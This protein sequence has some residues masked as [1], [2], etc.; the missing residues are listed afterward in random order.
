[1]PR[2]MNGAAVLIAANLCMGMAEAE[3]AFSHDYLELSYNRMHPNTGS[4]YE[5]ATLSGIGSRISLSLD[6]LSWVVVEHGNVSS[7]DFDD[8][9][10]RGLEYSALLFGAARQ[11]TDRG[12]WYFEAGPTF[13]RLT[14]GETQRSVVFALGIR[15][16]ISPRFE[17]GGGPRLDGVG[18]LD[19][20]TPEWTMRVNGL[21]SLSDRVALSASYDYREDD[22]Q[23]QLG[24]RVSW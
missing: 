14:Y 18:R 17:L 15:T 2:P 1:M 3:P 13:N 7:E 16:R 22:R 11:V 21:L 5:G 9:L 23:W 4:L 19:P 8:S 20:S 6:E 24:A 10:R 12:I